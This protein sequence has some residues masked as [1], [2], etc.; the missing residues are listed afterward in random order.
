MNFDIKLHQLPSFLSQIKVI[1]KEVEKDLNRHINDNNIATF[2]A[3]LDT[4]GFNLN[5]HKLT[6]KPTKNTT[7]NIEIEDKLD[8]VPIKDDKNDNCKSI[9]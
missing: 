8:S 6:I 2:L 4:I 9:W 1:S 3:H 5:L 7:I